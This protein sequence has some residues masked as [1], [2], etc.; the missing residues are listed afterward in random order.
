MKHQLQ[1]L[2]DRVSHLE[3][4]LHTIA[5]GSGCYYENYMQFKLKITQNKKKSSFRKKDN[6]C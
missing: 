3:E 1:L 2:I 5:A 6:K 4:L